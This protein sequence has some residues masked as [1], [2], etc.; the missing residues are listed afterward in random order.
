MTLAQIR[1]E[2]MHW[3]ATAPGS[4]PTSSARQWPRTQPPQ[5]RTSPAPMVGATLVVA[6]GGPGSPAS[7]RPRSNVALRRYVD[8]CLMSLIPP[9][10]N[11]ILRCLFPNAVNRGLIPA[12]AKPN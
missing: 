4:W 6:L 3:T 5:P 10:V 1:R 2:V 9:Q 7:D 12:A 11:E 8:T